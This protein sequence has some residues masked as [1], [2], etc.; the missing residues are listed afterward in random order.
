MVHGSVKTKKAP[1]RAARPGAAALAKKKAAPPASK[2]TPVRAAAAAR[3]KRAAAATAAKA[4]KARFDFDGFVGEAREELRVKLEQ[5]VA[6]FGLGSY[7]SFSVDQTRAVMEFSAGGRV[8]LTAKAQV[9]GS[10]SAASDS[11]LWSWA[12]AS[13]LPIARKRLAK[14][15]D[16]GK[17]NR[18]S[19]LTTDQWEATEADGWSMTAVAASILRA[20][21]AYRV[22]TRSGCVFVLLD[23]LEQTG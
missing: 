15:R 10:F 19:A 6:D 17:A 11:W 22:P 3:P 14:V 4:R 5:G 18:I 2:K 9:V 13:I 7:E 8:R 16:F 12:N 1:S 20:Q 23:G 21:C